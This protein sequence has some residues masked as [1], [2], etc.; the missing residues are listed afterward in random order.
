[1]SIKLSFIL[2]CYN[3]ERYIADCLDSIYAQDF[4][5]KNFEVIC[6]NDCSTDGTRSI[7]V[8]YAQKYANLTLIDHEHNMTAGGARNTGLDVAKG[9][10]IWFVDPDDVIN[11]ISLSALYAKAETN[12][13][14]LLFFNYTDS[15]IELHPYRIDSSF[16]DSVVMNGQEFVANYFPHQ[17]SQLG[18]VWRVLYRRQYLLDNHLTYPLIRKSQDVVFSY[19]SLL[20]AKRVAS[21]S[22]SCYLFRHNPNSVTHAKKTA[23]VLFSERFQL[24]GEL[25]RILSD[26]H[27]ILQSS[28]R[29]QLCAMRTWS[30]NP[31]WKEVAQLNDVECERYRMYVRI[32]SKLL[33]ELMQYMNR[34]TKLMFFASMCSLSWKISLRL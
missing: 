24:A 18:V 7:I 26:P 32:E 11:P 15:D 13:V 6:V 14:D 22:D 12:N 3:V 34:K 19:R 4:H 33:M 21:L 10:Y 16:V 5:E 30:C 17:L 20:K 8:D 27:F 28:I 1:M 23:K 31:E 2:P 9:E 29:K 25:Q